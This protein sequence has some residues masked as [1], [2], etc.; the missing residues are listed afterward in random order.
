MRFYRDASSAVRLEPIVQSKSSSIAQPLS[1]S[2]ITKLTN[3]KK[4]PNSKDSLKYK[5]TKN[6]NLSN[7]L[8]EDTSSDRFVKSNIKY[9]LINHLW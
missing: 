4:Q 1:N 3:N 2:E 5:S 8:D 9:Y 6:S 7:N